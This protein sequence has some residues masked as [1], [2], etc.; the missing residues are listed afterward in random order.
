M[1]EVKIV[2]KGIEN[3][4][5][6]KKGKINDAN[7]NL[8]NKVDQLKNIGNQRLKLKQ[9]M[10]K[11]DAGFYIENNVENNQNKINFKIT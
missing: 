9:Q 4:D 6:L 11:S 7:K 10:N 5:E 3:S 2:K 8:L 1:K